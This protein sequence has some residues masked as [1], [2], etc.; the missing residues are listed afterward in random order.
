MGLILFRNLSPA[1]THRHVYSP[2]SR[3][4][5]IEG[6]QGAGHSELIHPYS[7]FKSLA[8]KRGASGNLLQHCISLQKEAI[9]KHWWQWGAVVHIEGIQPTWSTEVVR[10]VF[11]LSL[12]VRGAGR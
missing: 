2:Q 1:I 7:L 3:A 12:G 6:K 4:L 8:T 10:L 11:L 9:S 5:L